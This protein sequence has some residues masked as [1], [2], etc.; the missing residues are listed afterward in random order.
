MDLNLFYFGW[1]GA[2]GMMTLAV[3]LKKKQL[4]I[5]IFIFSTEKFDKL[6]THILP[7]AKTVF[8]AYVRE[9][10]ETYWTCLQI[11]RVSPAPYDSSLCGS[12]WLWITH[13]R[14]GKQK[15]REPICQPQELP[16]LS[17]CISQWRSKQELAPAVKPEAQIASPLSYLAVAES[18][19]GPWLLAA[20]LGGHTAGTAL[21]TLKNRL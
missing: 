16:L 13:L 7:K 1:R 17:P 19:W 12:C 5:Q 14:D 20:T 3:S 9:R 6:L 21:G 4:Q 18:C 15:V 11:S 10:M 2:G 8:I